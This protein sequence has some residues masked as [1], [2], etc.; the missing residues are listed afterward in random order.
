[1]APNALKVK[2]IFESC[3][4]PVARR[5]WQAY[6]LAASGD[7]GSVC[8]KTLVLRAGWNSRP[9]V[10]RQHAASASSA[11]EPA[12]ARLTPIWRFAGW[13]KAGS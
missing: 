11:W 8:L 12:S 1:M 6:L 13:L 5:W 7:G 4:L 2:R 10:S 3:R 9:A